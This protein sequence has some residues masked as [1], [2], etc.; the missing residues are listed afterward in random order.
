MGDYTWV[1]VDESGQELRSIEAFGSQR[2]AEAWL[3]GTWESLAEEGASSVRLVTAG[4]VVYEM[5]L[6]PG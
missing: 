6:S 5:K 4:E 1:L 3:T 2:D